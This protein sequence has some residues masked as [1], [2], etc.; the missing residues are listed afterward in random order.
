MEGE[1]KGNGEKAEATEVEVLIFFFICFLNA[2]SSVARSL[3]ATVAAFAVVSP[4]YPIL[5]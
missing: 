5:V 1:G 2:V 3:L 4:F